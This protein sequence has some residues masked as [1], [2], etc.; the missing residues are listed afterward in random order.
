METAATHITFWCNTTC[1]PFGITIDHHAYTLCTCQYTLLDQCQHLLYVVVPRILRED[2]I[3]GFPL[4]HGK[5]LQGVY[6]HAATATLVIHYVQPSVQVISPTIYTGLDPFIVAH[7]PNTPLVL[8][9][10]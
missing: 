3:G 9:H 8:S 2:N 1:C 5:L 4:V 6:M 7:S 10:S